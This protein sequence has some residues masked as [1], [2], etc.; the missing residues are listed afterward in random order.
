MNAITRQ[1]LCMPDAPLVTF[2]LN[3]REVTSRANET[4]L[5]VAEREGVV[6]PRLCYMDG[7]EA[8]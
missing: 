7:M 6:I 2:S 5:Q 1:E 3:G 4:L 8:V